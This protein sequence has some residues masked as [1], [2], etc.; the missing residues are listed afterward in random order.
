[1]NAALADLQAPPNGAP[2]TDWEEDTTMKLGTM[3][4]LLITLVLAGPAKGGQVVEDGKLFHHQCNDRNP[5]NAGYC[6]GFITGIAEV[7][8]DRGACF[9]D[10]TTMGQ[11]TLF[12]RTWVARRPHLH[13]YSANSLVVASLKEGFPCPEQPKLAM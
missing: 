7:I 11:I 4:L 3:A 5:V 13:R 1:M 12:V 8:A 9:T 10:G 6:M 2:M